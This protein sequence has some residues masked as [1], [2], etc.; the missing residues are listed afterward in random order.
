MVLTDEI[1]KKYKGRSI[2]WLEDKFQ[3]LI[4]AKVRAIEIRQYRKHPKSRN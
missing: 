4:N 1:K 3:D 2:S